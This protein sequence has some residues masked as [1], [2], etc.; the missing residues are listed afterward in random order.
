MFAHNCF[1]TCSNRLLFPKRHFAVRRVGSF[2]FAWLFSILSTRCCRPHRL[3]LHL[4]MCASVCMWGFTHIH[5]YVCRLL[6]AEVCVLFKHATLESVDAFGGISY[7][8]NLES[9]F[10]YEN[11][12]ESFY[13]HIESTQFNC[14]LTFILY[15]NQLLW[16]TNSKQNE[17]MKMKCVH[18]F[19]CVRIQ[20]G[21]K[22]DVL[23]V[24]KAKSFVMYPIWL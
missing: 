24:I 3:S 17:Q 14:K 23:N 19:A 2:C 5:V 12:K 9:A 10:E 11:R 6:S 7:F 1:T 15:L 8:P 20:A 13:L 21:R 22:R 4:S 16:T 18:T